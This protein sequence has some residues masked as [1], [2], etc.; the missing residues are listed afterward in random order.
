[1]L[2]RD[3][4]LLG[5]AL[6]KKWPL[7]KTSSEETSV[8]DQLLKRLT[9]GKQSPLNLV[10]SGCEPESKN[11]TCTLSSVSFE[12]KF[13]VFVLLEI[14]HLSLTKFCPLEYIETN[15]FFCDAEQTHKISAHLICDGV[16]NC[17]KTGADESFSICNPWEIRSVAVSPILINFLAALCCAFYLA[18]QQDN[19]RPRWSTWNAGVVTALKSINRNICTPSPRN[20]EDMQNAIHE[21]SPVLQLSLARITTNIEIGSGGST[22]TFFEPTVESIL[23]QGEDEE[24]EFLGLTKEDNKSSTKFKIAVM[25][26]TEPKGIVSKIKTFLL[27][28]LPYKLRIFTKT[29]KEVV[30]A[31]FGM[32]TI[33]AQDVKDVGTVVSLYSF[34]NNVL[35]GNDDRLDD[36][37]LNDYITNLAAVTGVIF[38]LRLLN[39]FAENDVNGESTSFNFHKIPF[40]TEAFVCIQT[41][42][43]SLRSFRTK[44]AIQ[45]DLDAVRNKEGEEAK[46]IW[47]HVCDKS[48]DINES[49]RRMETN[50]QT[51]GKIK[52]VCCVG[53]IL[54]GSMLI[55]L[56]LR[57]DLRIRGLLG[58]TKVTHMIDSDPSNLGLRGLTEMGDL[59]GTDP[60]NLHLNECKM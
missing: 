18:R 52:I 50:N 28:R 29:T 36:F 54:Q 56:T 49:E 2:S 19:R 39:S 31:L 42:R 37:H 53:D 13:A 15:F 17:P 23:A 16:I 3:E 38:L 26:E 57:K 35:Q 60:S 27:G 32:I 34:H 46:R 5:E 22:T 20:E 6:V 45:D 55:I 12:N 51:R 11:C 43:E 8:S 9:T 24:T 14:A 25:K 59:I 58:L 44:A 48:E 30:T 10:C 1:M 7:K 40:V 47:E 4:S 21:L 33:P 41:A